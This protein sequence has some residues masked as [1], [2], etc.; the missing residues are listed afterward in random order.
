MRFPTQLPWLSKKSQSHCPMRNLSSWMPPTTNSV[1]SWIACKGSTFTTPSW[2]QATWP[3]EQTEPVP[4][5]RFARPPPDLDGD[6]TLYL[7]RFLHLVVDLQLEAPRLRTFDVD[8][9]ERLGDTQTMG[10]L[11][12]DMN[13]GSPV[14]YRIQEDRILKN[15]ELRYYDHPKFGV[16][17]KVTR[18]EEEEAT[19][20]NELLGYGTE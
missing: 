15:G 14:Y 1:T 16:L 2:T 3:N 9:Q 10:E 7:N 11:L 5:H 20:V 18:V 4:L 6:L 13:A 8:E 12:D 17:A 19:D